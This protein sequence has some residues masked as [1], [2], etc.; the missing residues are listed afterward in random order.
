M[1]T[2]FSV[3]CPRF[4][5]TITADLLANYEYVLGLTFRRSY[6]SSFLSFRGSLQNLL[7][8][9]GEPMGLVVQIN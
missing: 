9:Q 6:F 3:F 8:S 2:P 7:K 4:Q 5:Y 1:L